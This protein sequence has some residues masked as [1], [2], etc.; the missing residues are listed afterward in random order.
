MEI[1]GSDGRWL[2][3][4]MEGLSHGIV[5]L[6]CDGRLSYVNGLARRLLGIITSSPSEQAPVAPFGDLLREDDTPCP[7]SECPWRISL[8]TGQTLIDQRLGLRRS[9]GGVIWLSFTCNP[10]ACPGDKLPQAVIITFADISE[11]RRLEASLREENLRLS[12]LMRA[13]RDGIAI[14][15]QQHQVVDANTRF[16]EMLGYRIDEVIGLETWQYEASLTEEQIREEFY[17]LSLADM[18]VETRHR[19]KDGTVFDVEVGISGTM[20]AGK[21]VVLVICRDISDRKKAE[22]V[23]RQSEE[24]FRQ[25]FQT[26][27]DPIVII[28]MGNRRIVDVNQEFIAATGLTWAEAVG[29]TSLELKIWRDVNDRMRF[30]E[31]L[32]E[33]GMVCS[34]ET[35]FLRDGK[36]VP[37]LISAAVFE[38]DGEPHIYISTRNIEELKAAETQLRERDE[39]SR[40]ILRTAMDGFCRVDVRGRVLE[41][42]EAYCRMTGYRQEELL[43]LSLRDLDAAM[44]E[45]EITRGIENLV[46]QGEARFESR[47]RR[48]DGSIVDVE[49]SAQCR[50]V[51]GTGEFV[52]FLRDITDSKL[53]ARI[54]G[55]LYQLGL[56]LSRA[57]S[58]QETLQAA[59][60]AALDISG[61]ECGGVYLV[62]PASGELQLSAHLGLSPELL[63]EALE[64]RRDDRRFSLV[65]QGQAVY[66]DG[67]ELDRLNPG[68]GGKLT[69]LAVIPVVHQE[70][71]I[72]CLNLGAVSAERIPVAV[73]AGLESLGSQL[74]GYLA[75]T[76]AEESLRESRSRYTALFEH[77]PVAVWEQDYSA[78]KHELDRLSAA[79]VS[80]FTSH[81]ALH[82]RE[83]FRC[84]GLARI[85]QVNRQSQA[86]FKSAD[87]EELNRNLPRHFTRAAMTVISRGMTALAGGELFFQDEMP[88]VDLCGQSHDLIIR[89]VVCPGHEQNLSRVLVSF[90][91]ITERKRAEAQR[92]RNEALLSQANRELQAISACRQALIHAQDE[93][94]LLSSI[95]RIICEEAG[96]AMAWV[97]MLEN[98][99]SLAH[100]PWTWYGRE[101][102]YLTE[103]RR[104]LVENR[105]W[106]DPLQSAFEQGRTAFVQDFARD[107]AAAPLREAALARGYRS[108]IYLPLR[109][110]MGMVLGTLNIYSDQPDAFTAVETNLLEGLAGDLAF[111]IGFLRVRQ[112]QERNN[113]V[114]RAR[115]DLIRYAQNHT[116]SELFEET[117]N[118]AEKL[119]GS[120]I[121]FYHF[122]H[123]E[124]ATISLQGW[125]T[126]TKKE[127]CR[128]EGEGLHYDIAA[129]GVWVDCYH[130]RRP[131]ICNDYIALPHRRGMPAGHAEVNRFLTVPVIRGE[132]IK[133]ILAV[134]NKPDPYMEKDIEIV[135]LLAELAWEIVERKME[136]DRREEVERQLRQAQKMEAIGTL[137]GGIAHD[138]NNILSAILGYGEMALDD[139]RSGH[140]SPGD[141]EKI[142][143]AADRAKELVKQILTFSRKVEVS[144]MPL[145]LNRQVEQAVGLLMK[146]VPRMIDFDVQLGPEVWEIIADANQV[147]QILMNLTVNA[148]DAMNGEGTITIT[149]AN[150]IVIDQLCLTCG[151]LFSG[152]HVVLEVADTG[153]GFDETTRKHIFEPFY[154][155]KEVGK[156][157]GLGLSTVYG[158]VLG[159]G[160]HVTCESNPGEGTVFTVYFPVEKAD[161]Q[162]SGTEQ[163]GAV[164][165]TA[166]GTGRILLV[167][168]EEPLRNLASRQLE[169]AGY[170]VLTADCGEAALEIYRSQAEAIDLVIMDMSMP[171]MG[172][173]RALQHL[174]EI[175][176][177]VRVIIATGY[178][179]H[180]QVED[181]LAMGAA[182][183]IAKPFKQTDLLTAVRRV[184]AGPVPPKNEKYQARN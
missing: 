109:S 80:D 166:G 154:T 183:Y 136:E 75:R 179:A 45:E 143:F 69:A 145:N 103:A 1:T 2:D 27:P 36:P 168:D 40:Q 59:L 88:I 101:D 73:R 118:M 28:R 85:L 133:A 142:L 50:A 43:L 174:F 11:Q 93:M 114:N 117:L 182:A 120:C 123:E 51:D 125:S 72:A 164:E 95:C 160:G 37:V 77:A 146:A 52:S 167:D 130:Q 30:Y 90:L 64:V 98:D 74:G 62:E 5:R 18:I 78:L 106:R 81:F 151:K 112:E 61:V 83:V 6:E 105:Y 49:V 15:N 180:G 141:L 119:T 169:R 102:G 94:V 8:A 110:D 79:G 149:T 53:S 4:I 68:L 76:L 56:T 55:Q 58:V 39:C 162:N 165:E 152:P 87:I 67:V 97:C 153:H 12:A 17:D 32:A 34:M 144:F 66:L 107:A 26:S 159:H 158:I 148:A 155:T 10:V 42:N 3:E 84:A 71:V 99:G 29:R 41:V 177:K 135:L 131:Q 122:I 128:A 47:Q 121:G 171:G 9:D 54:A 127:F 172:G 38:L 184:L 13:S 7:E 31:M 175:D 92:R 96:Y 100:R 124:Q 89:L 157:T 113:Q 82:P 181:S 132:S 25:A 140:A 139:A 19:R 163:A 46:T 178:A 161:W 57:A 126:R 150:K 137:A 91:D 23:L 24:K 44:S 147:E 104:I 170:E 173:Y 33:N 48:K 156:G 21:P 116:L 63:A 20:V 22:R 70:K 14:I 129:A 134:G 65:L 86:I 108:S 115:V 176:P 16:A 35:V 60:A 138:F 111:G